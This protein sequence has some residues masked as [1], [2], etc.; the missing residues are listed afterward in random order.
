[1]SRFVIAFL[2][3]VLFVSP[4]Q[5]DVISFGP[6]GGAPVPIAGSDD[7]TGSLITYSSILIHGG[8]AQ[9]ATHGPTSGSITDDLG[10]TS[11]YDG[12]FFDSAVDGDPTL[13]TKIS[14]VARR[15]IDG[16][17][18]SDYA[19]Y[20]GFHVTFSAPIEFFSFGFVDMDGN[21]SAGRNEW[22]GSFAYNSSTATTSIP[23]I[24]LGDSVASAVAPTGTTVDWSGLTGAPTT[25]GVAFNNDNL[26]GIE[27]SDPTGQVKFD[28]GGNLVTDMYF[29][30]GLQG[31]PGS[32]GQNNS[33][34]T[35]FAV[36]EAANTVPEPSAAMLLGFGALLLA[37]RRK[38]TELL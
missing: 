19:N 3:C 24:T 35:G 38:K 13:T 28:Y 34:V 7:G 15:R 29:M 14:S 18:A 30:F 26:E 1:M 21:V 12:T 36:L 33:G 9:A 8:T 37:S 20:I 31:E 10:G 17:M 2:T 25:F 4:A 6:T 27:P 23:T 11:P 16:G 22:A 5:A 32:N